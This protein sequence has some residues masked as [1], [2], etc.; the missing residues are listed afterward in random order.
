MTILPLLEI[1]EKLTAAHRELLKLSEENTQALV[2]NDYERLNTIVH[3]G[4]KLVRLIAELE[5]QCA[6]TIGEYLISR[7]FLPDPRVTISDL[8]KIVFKADEKRALIERQKDMLD[9]LQSLKRVNE[10]N[11]RLLQLS[12]SYINETLDLMTG[13]PEDEV[14]YHKPNVRG[15][16][17]KRFSTFDSRA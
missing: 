3:K 15:N 17:M 1:M 8:I 16:G 13:S 7:A 12:L 9:V 2:Q 5:R 10:H 4:N 11:Q 14:V 6:Q